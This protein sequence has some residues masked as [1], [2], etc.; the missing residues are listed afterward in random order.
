MMFLSRM[1]AITRGHRGMLSIAVF[2]SVLYTAFSILPA[3]IIR[4]MLT[5][6]GPPSLPGRWVRPHRR[7]QGPARHADANLR[8]AAA[9]VD[10]ISHPPAV[11][12]D[13]GQGYRR[14]RDYRVLHRARRDPADQCGDGPL[15]DRH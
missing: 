10:G 2:G 7:L 8:A 11:G 9:P 15:A 5:A 6:L 4:Q 1:W 3:L 13:R 12:H 14:R